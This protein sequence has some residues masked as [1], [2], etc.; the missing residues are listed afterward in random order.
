M[1]S[2]VAVRPKAEFFK[3]LSWPNFK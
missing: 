2:D 1:F 3:G